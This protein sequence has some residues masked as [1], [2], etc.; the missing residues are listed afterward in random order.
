MAI[1]VFL[2]RVDDLAFLVQAGAFARMGHLAGT[3]QL[4][5][6]VGGREVVDLITHDRR[7]AEV[8]C[9]WGRSDLPIQA[10]SA[11]AVRRGFL[12]LE[13]RPAEIAAGPEQ[14]ERQNR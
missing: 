7:L 10:V 13:E 11:P 3:S 14:R 9:R 8:E 5:V 2:L 1:L 6:L 12:A 4:L